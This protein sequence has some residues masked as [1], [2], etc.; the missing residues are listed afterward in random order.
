V[1]QKNS[2]KILKICGPI[3][4]I[5]GII[6]FYYI[7]FGG[8]AKP[9]DVLITVMFIAGGIYFTWLGNNSQKLTKK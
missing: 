9:K 6:G 3:L 7:M 4:I 1:D 2:V 8:D 5:C